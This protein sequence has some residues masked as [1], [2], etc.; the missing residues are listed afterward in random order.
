VSI[1]AIT[2]VLLGRLPLL[3][4]LIVGVI[5]LIVRR[6]R[7]PRSAFW[8]G[9]AG[10]VVLT[11]SAVTDVFW[12]SWVPNLYRDSSVADVT[13]LISVVG[14]TLSLVHAIG[15]GLIIASALIRPAVPPADFGGFAAP[16]AGFAP[17][18]P[19]GVV[20]PAAPQ[21]GPP[22]PNPNVW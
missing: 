18:Y 13:V 15:I 9:V 6:A 12:V 21:S 8:L 19:A 14:L 3:V 17:P 20:P 22:Q 2:G 5:L 10:V 1:G 4:V 11:L 16:G 7:M